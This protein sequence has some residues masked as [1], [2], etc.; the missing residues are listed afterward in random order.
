MRLLLCAA[1]SPPGL[2]A[3]TAFYSAHCTNAWL[4]FI[5]N[6]A[7]KNATN[8]PRVVS[9]ACSCCATGLF[10]PP[11]LFVALDLKAKRRSS[12][13]VRDALL[14]CLRCR[15]V[16]NMGHQGGLRLTSTCVHRWIWI[17]SYRE[18]GREVESPGADE[19]ARPRTGGDRSGRSPAGRLSR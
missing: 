10:L 19:E 12:A 18:R 15:S 7:L 9:L 1:L 16:V 2:S 6:T 14:L 17:K 3:V 13:Q 8:I 4:L 11:S 5:V